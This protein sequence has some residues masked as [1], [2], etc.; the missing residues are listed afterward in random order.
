[1]NEELLEQIFSGVAGGVLVL[2]AQ[3]VAGHFADYRDRQKV[4]RWLDRYGWADKEFRSTRVIASHTNLTQ[5]RVRYICSIDD[6][7]YLSRGEKDDMWGRVG[8][9]DFTDAFGG[10]SD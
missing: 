8:N 5:E 7:I 3:W 6:R 1:M 4:Y 9:K 10:D 2:L